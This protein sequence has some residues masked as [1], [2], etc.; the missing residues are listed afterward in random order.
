[1]QIS[2]DRI[3]APYALWGVGRH[4]AVPTSV[5]AFDRLRFASLLRQSA[6]VGEV[7]LDR[8]SRVPMDRQ[9]EVLGQI[10]DVVGETPRAV[11]LHSTGATGAI[12]DALERHPIAF[13]ILHWWRGTRAKTTRAI[14]LGCL[15]S[16]N[17]HEASSPKVIDSIPID[18]VITEADFPH[19]RRYDKRADRPGA[20]ATAE[21]ALARRH[22]VSAD[23]MRTRMWLT[24]APLVE[25]APS[26]TISS[27]LRA[28]VE[29]VRGTAGSQASPGSRVAGQLSFDPLTEGPDRVEP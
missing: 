3:Y 29:S 19:T 16:L 6:F 27:D 12:L 8:R 22:D 5:D 9:A 15:F 4:P 17:G 20:V 24:L 25:A 14:E 13:P 18:R 2:H 28:V 1:L 7:G 21:L 10:L 23:E 11:S 26:E